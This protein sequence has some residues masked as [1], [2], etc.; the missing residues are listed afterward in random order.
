MID[1]NPSPFGNL[2]SGLLYVNL[3]TPAKFAP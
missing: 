2:L 1:F 3:V